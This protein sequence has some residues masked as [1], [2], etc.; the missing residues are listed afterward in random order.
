MFAPFKEVS[1][2]WYAILDGTDLACT[3]GAVDCDVCEPWVYCEDA[4]LFCVPWLLFDERE[5][6]VPACDL[7][8]T[9]GGAPDQ[10][11]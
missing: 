4:K 6:C 7:G 1:E 2:N 9:V 10:V 3:L 8:D 11:L 5:D